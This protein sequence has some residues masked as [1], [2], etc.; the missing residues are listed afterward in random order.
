MKK[1]VFRLIALAAVIAVCAAFT[2]CLFPMNSAN[3]PSITADDSASTVP[4]EQRKLMFA[5]NVTSVQV[6]LE[7]VLGYFCYE[8]NP[9]RILTEKSKTEEKDDSVSFTVTVYDGAKNADGSNKASEDQ[10]SYKIGDNG[11]LYLNSSV[12]GEVEVSATAANGSS[13]NSVKLPINGRSLSLW[14]ILIAGIA[15]YLL[16]S[17]VIGRGKLF[18]EEF[19]REGM[20]KRHKTIVRITALIVGLLMI[21]TVVIAFIDKYDKMRILKAAMF[22]CMLIV[23]ITSML[24]LRKC[25][26]QEAKMK[27]RDGRYSGAAKKSPSAAFEFDDNEPTVD[28]IKP[29]KKD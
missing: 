1:T 13:I 14:D 19:I 21:G 17:A 8:D 29:D 10:Y 25:V 6:N 15:V 20:E 2:A 11:Y 9:L 28:D 3:T 27:A 26:D 18:E 5:Q 4:Y 22:V 23:F 12:I 16:V 24:M 7:T